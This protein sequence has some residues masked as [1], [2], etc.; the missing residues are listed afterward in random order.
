MVR[1]P[2]SKDSTPSHYIKQWRK[3]RG[4]SLRRLAERME[5]Q[6]GE[7]LISA[8][9]LSRIERGEQP[10]SEPVLE[11]LA[12][13]LDT[14]RWSLLSVNPETESDVVDLMGVIRKMDAAQRERALRIVKAANE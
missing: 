4:L 9:S 2:M 11:A 7:E 12:L 3:H 6:P 5:V 1:Y 8:M 14:P 13:A 10:Y